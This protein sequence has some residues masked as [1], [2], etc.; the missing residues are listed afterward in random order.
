MYQQAG[1]PALCFLVWAVVGL[2]S[3]V[4]ESGLC[5]LSGE[6]ESGGGESGGGSSGTILLTGRETCRDGN[7]DADH[8]IHDGVITRDQ[9]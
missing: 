2:G 9:S 6:G 3:G 5:G 4:C 8:H 1:P 7:A